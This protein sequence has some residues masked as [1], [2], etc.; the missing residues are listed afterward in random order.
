MADYSEHF[1]IRGKDVNQHASDY[2][3]G[4]LGTYRR[5]NM[6]CIHG[7]IPDSN[8]QGMQQLLSDSPWSH[9][10][11]MTQVADEANGLLGGNRHSAL[12]I[13]ETSFV[14]KGDSSVGVQR[15]YC[16]RLGKKENCQMGVFA[17]L[18]LGDKA[19]VVDFRLFLPES[20]AQSTERCD[21]AQIPEDQRQ[22]RTKL[23]L[24]LEMIKSARAR[25]MQFQWVSADAAYGCSSEFCA[26]IE[27][28]GLYY[29]LDASLGACVW[30]AD[31]Q[32]YLPERQGNRGR[33][34][35]VCQAGNAQARRWKLPDLLRERFAKHGKQIVIRKTTKGELRARVW[36]CPVWVWED[37]SAQ[38]IARR[39]VV[40]EMEGG[41]LKV[42]WTNAPKELS[43][44]ELAYMQGQRHWIERSFEDAKSQLGMADYEVRKWRG[45]HHHM[46]LVAL[47]MLFILKE[48]VEHEESAPL[49]S[50][51][52]I[53]E[54]LAFY[55]PRRRRKEEEVISDLVRR[56]KQRQAATKNHAR[57]QLKKRL[58][59]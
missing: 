11:L 53:V 13:D 37:G 3:S 39:I 12:L 19:A 34:E 6:E 8:Y 22:H 32:P 7:D 14:K 35:T 57:S 30:D 10:Q 49:L 29:M 5:K 20:W 51:R 26:E 54:L 42:S 43:D 2:L 21:K 38:A 55:L 23:E 59:D 15:Q 40:R 47:A 4:L 1:L 28:L 52:D 44:E 50:A 17:C 27:K 58:E 24:A 9:A 41:E 48:R 36:V 56:H 45:W 31:P 25:G 16:G 18:G 33:P 46:A